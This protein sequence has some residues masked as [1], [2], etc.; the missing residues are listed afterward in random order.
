[1]PM[2]LLHNGENLDESHAIF[3]VVRL[4]SCTPTGDP[5]P[6][7]TSRFNDQ[8]GRW[9]KASI[10]PLGVESFRRQIS[11]SP[12]ANRALSRSDF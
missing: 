1:M 4:W 10:V 8:D 12:I 2:G 11:K 9:E 5:D 3:L 7:F 6:I